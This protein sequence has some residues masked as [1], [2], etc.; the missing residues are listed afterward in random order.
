MKILYLHYSLGAGGA[1]QFL[2]DLANRMALNP[3]N[4]VSI[5][6]ILDSSNS[7]MSHFLPELSKNVEFINLHKRKGISLA[8]MIEVWRKICKEKP[9]IVH[10]H[11]SFWLIIFPAIFYRKAHYVMTIHNLVERWADGMVN[12]IISNWLYKDKVL[13]VTISQ[14]CHRSYY[15]YYNR[16]NDI[17]I[18]N[19]REPVKLS[20]RY[21]DV[22]RQIESI[23][24]NPKT[25]VFVHVAR[26]HPQKN[27]NRLFNTF[28]RLTTEGND[29]L[30]IVVGD[31]Y[32]GYIK[33]YKS[34]SN[35]LFV[36]KKKNVGDYL[37]VAD[38][39]TLSS[40][41]EGLPISLLEAMSLGVIPICTPAGGIVDVI[42]DGVNGYMS[43][44]IDD[45]LYYQC[46]KRALKERGKISRAQIIDDFQ[47][48]YS[49][50]ICAD[51]YYK[52]YKGLL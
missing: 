10:V 21:D 30:L 37:A 22:K 49:M 43:T 32:D 50:K 3:E 40:D 4:K 23:K 42:H 24:C 38:F 15:A 28:T 2:V 48:K 13:A 25:S 9:D 36:G 47:N 26:N 16:D 20:D 34:Y 45:E 17:T 11:C 29:V 7:S 46:V 8:N 27:H 35:I 14:A 6:T 39:F 51:K 1:E 52:V 44:E 18:D 12:R 31:K 41:I 19:G 5:L 33:K